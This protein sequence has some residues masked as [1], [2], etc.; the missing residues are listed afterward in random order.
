VGEGRGVV[1]RGVDVDDA[2]FCAEVER[3]DV[4]G[5]DESNKPEDVAI[6]SSERL[7]SCAGER[8][9]LEQLLGNLE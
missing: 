7:L 5:V 2:G 3:V 6:K 9:Y 1:R 4:R 8:I